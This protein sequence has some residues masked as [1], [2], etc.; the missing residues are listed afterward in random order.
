MSPNSESRPTPPI[1]SLIAGGTAGGIEAFLTYPFEFAKTRVQLRSEGKASVPAIAS[2]NPFAVVLQVVRTEGY[3]ALYKGCSPLVVGSVAK[4]AIRFLSFDAIKN[5]FK[6][7]QTGTLSP[8]RN[9]AAGMTAGIVA[10]IT[11]V[12]PTERIK[13]A[14]IDDARSIRRFTGARHAVSELWRE[15]GLRNIYRGFVGTTAK[16][17]GTTAF[18]LGSYNILKDYESTH[19]IEQTTVINFANGAVAGIVTTYATQPF[20]AVKTRSQS[21]KGAS[22]VEAVTSIWA[23]FGLKGFWKG[24]VMRLGRTVMAGGILFTVYEGVSK[25]LLSVYDRVQDKES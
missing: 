18:R 24:T 16:Q 10:S 20:D 5:A 19:G 1:V 2:K 14:L 8:A 3:K 6:D 13:T 25:P 4:D 15:G 11:C 17:M 9:I 12:T 21:A 22:A 7:P 23:D